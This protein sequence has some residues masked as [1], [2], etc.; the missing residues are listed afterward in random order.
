MPVARGSAQG[1]ADLP[2][3]TIA[4]NQGVVGVQYSPRSNRWGSEFTLRGVERQSQ[5]NAGTGLFA[6]DAYAVA[7][8]TGWVSLPGRVM[9]RGAVLNLTDTT[10]YEW[11]NVRGRQS[12]DPL[13]DRYS[14][15]GVSGLVSLS[16]AW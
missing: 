14:S 3:D 8:L 10:Y 1:G 13:I 15:P 5:R 7:D 2:L 9:L 16:Y 6:P 4:P 12:S 11:T